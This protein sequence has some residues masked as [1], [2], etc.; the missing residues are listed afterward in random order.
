MGRPLR[1]KL[2][3]RGR[4]RGPTKTIRQPAAERARLY[5][6][7]EKTEHEKLIEKIEAIR[8]EVVK[9]RT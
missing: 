8:A 4:P 9:G 5:P 2:G 7:P 3:P 6:R 1:D